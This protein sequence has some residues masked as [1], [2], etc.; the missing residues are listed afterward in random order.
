MKHLPAG[1]VRA[2]DVPA[3]ALSVGGEDERA[4]ARADEDSN[5][6]HGLLLT[7]FDDRRTEWEADSCRALHKYTREIL[8]VT[9]SYKAPQNCDEDGDGQSSP[10]HEQM[11]KKNIYDYGP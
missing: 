8:A 10:K 1:E 4:L 11:K 3:V 2:A 5:L 7:I 6:A 9:N